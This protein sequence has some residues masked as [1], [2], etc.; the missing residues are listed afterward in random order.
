MRNPILATFRIDPEKWQ[1]FKGKAK[2]DGTNASAVLIQLVTAYLDGNID[3]ILDK[4]AS[5]DNNLDK[6][7]ENAI[8]PL[9]GELAALKKSS[10]LV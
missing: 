2:G 1:A 5:L 8:A 6:R 9:R 7:I 4:S 10:P 3:R